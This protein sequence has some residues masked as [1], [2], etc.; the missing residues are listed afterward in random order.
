MAR[1][2]AGAAL[3]RFGGTDNLVALQLKVSPVSGI[4][5]VES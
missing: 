5:S 3:N 4:S 2:Q 1:R